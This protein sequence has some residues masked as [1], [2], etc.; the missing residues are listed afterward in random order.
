MV[1]RSAGGYWPA[2]VLHLLLPWQ[3]Q[4]E[5]PG[6]RLRNQE[7][8]CSYESPRFTA[9]RS[10]GCRSIRQRS[11]GEP[12]HRTQSAW[13]NT[14]PMLCHVTKPEPQGRRQT[15]AYHR[16]ASEQQVV[17]LCRVRTNDGVPSPGRSPQDELQVSLLGRTHGRSNKEKDRGGNRK[18]SHYLNVKDLLQTSCCPPRLVQCANLPRPPYDRNVRYAAQWRLAQHG[19]CW[20]ARAIMS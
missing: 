15:A 5:S 6:V 16:C 19:R 13:R 11:A 7:A 1:R 3:L 2:V 10:G 4:I 20:P 9:R 14:K 8:S 18:R 12:S 17:L